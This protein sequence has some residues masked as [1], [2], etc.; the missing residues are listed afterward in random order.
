MSASV[1][2]LVALIS[3]SHIVLFPAS[4]LSLL[5]EVAQTAPRLDIS[6]VT[7]STASVR[8]GLLPSE[9]HFLCRAPPPTPGQSL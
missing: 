8:E 2:A 7:P 6:V 3:T 1:S 4:E 5:F 9:R